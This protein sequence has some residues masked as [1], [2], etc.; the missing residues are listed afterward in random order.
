MLDIPEFGFR[1]SV[2]V[3]NCTV[4]IVCDWIESSLLFD[5]TEISQAQVSD[6]LH[7]QEY[8]PRGDKEERD[9]VAEFQGMLWM[10]LERRARLLGNVCLFT[11]LGKRVVRRP[12]WEDS[13]AS[14]F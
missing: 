12:D 6:I 2:R 13:A 3:H 7:E 8:Y 5:E 10:E 11:I 4:A 9:F 14:C 1:R